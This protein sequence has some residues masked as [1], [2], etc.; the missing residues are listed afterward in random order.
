VDLK[1][2]LTYFGVMKKM[3]KKVFIPKLTYIKEN[4]AVYIKEIGG[5]MTKREAQKELHEALEKASCELCDRISGKIFRVAC[6]CGCEEFITQPDEY[7][8]YRIIE[9]KL[10]FQSTE[11]IDDELKYACRDCGK[12]Y[13]EDEFDVV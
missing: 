12:E 2:K 13:S 8:V 6:D 11:L 3:N 7:G 1:E 10:A 5:P 9:G 4:E